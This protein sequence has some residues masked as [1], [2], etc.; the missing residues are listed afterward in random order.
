MQHNKVAWIENHSSEVLAHRRA[1]ME[2]E[3]YSKMRGKLEDMHRELPYLD[4]LAGSLL[5]II[6]RLNNRIERLIDEVDSYFEL[7]C[8]LCDDTGDSSGYG[9][10]CSCPA[11]EKYSFG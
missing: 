3:R 9:N 4:P 10:R 2:L 7:Q 5:A 6:S 8:S 11:G 1:G